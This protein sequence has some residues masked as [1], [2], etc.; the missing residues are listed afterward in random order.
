MKPYTNSEGRNLFNDLNSR[1]L[2]S[3]VNNNNN[4]VSLGIKSGAW[5]QPITGHIRKA[6]SVF[7][8][9][10]GDLPSDSFISINEV[11]H[12]A[13]VWSHDGGFT[14]NKDTVR[15]YINNE[16]MVTSKA[17]W[18]VDDTKSEVIKLG[19]AT[20]Q[21]SPNSDHYGSAIFDNVKI[22]NYCKTE[23]NIETEGVEKDISYTANE[24]LEISSDNI[25]FYG[26]GSTSLPI[27]F[28]A[29]PAGTSKTIYVRPAKNDNF[30]QSS[31]TAN[32]I[33]EW[34]TTV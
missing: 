18:E 4:I 32:I 27:V 15:L 23:F 3:M 16:L 21:T 10:V 7:E 5:L 26:M 33:I 17:T 22:Y 31:N 19:G 11:V 13:F 2:F 24:F 8:I 14:D 29:V 6:L 12:V 30:A 34:L 28:Q 25:T 20:A 1:L 9:D